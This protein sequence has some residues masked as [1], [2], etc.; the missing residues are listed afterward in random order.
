[1]EERLLENRTIYRFN[2][3][4]G[5]LVDAVGGQVRATTGLW[6]FQNTSKGRVSVLVFDAD[7]LIERVYVGKESCPQVVYAEK[8]G[9]PLGSLDDYIID[10]THIDIT[11][12]LN[13]I[14][15]LK[16]GK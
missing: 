16:S 5:K 15:N 10:E 8:M 2:K 4:G 3:K 12:L 1:M 9:Y 14:E 7:N 6:G 11:K 13:D